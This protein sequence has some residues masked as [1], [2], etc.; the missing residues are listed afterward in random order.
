MYLRTVLSL[1]MACAAISGTICYQTDSCNVVEDTSWF[2]ISR[3]ID[4][5]MESLP[6]LI[7]AVLISM[8]F[9]SILGWRNVNKRRSRGL[10]VA[11]LFVVSTIPTFLLGYFSLVT[12]QDTPWGTLDDDD[13]PL[14]WPIALCCLVL[15]NGLVCE[16]YVSVSSELRRHLN[17]NY[18]L[19]ARSRG[20][21]IFKQLYPGLIGPVL[22]LFLNRLSAAFPGLMVIEYQFGITG[23]G[24][25]LLTSFEDTSNNTMLLLV[26]ISWGVFFS[27]LR[28]IFESIEQTV[29]PRLRERV[30]K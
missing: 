28:L 21:R 13:N 12:F 3:L 20:L 4:A 18:I 14:R 27:S 9:G 23:I 16:A 2:Y 5:W 25:L 26:I 24:R 11:T 1:L 22:M 8:L 10:S 7:S 15:G 29:D 30:W 17:S 19:F 6:L